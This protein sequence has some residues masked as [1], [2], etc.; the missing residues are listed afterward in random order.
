MSHHVRLS[1]LS[2]S[3]LTMSLGTFCSPALAAKPTD[4][5]AVA[6]SVD[7]ILKENLAEEGVAPADLTADEDFLRR[8]SI[9][10]TGR[11]PTPAEMTRFG[12]DPDPRKREKKIEELL[13]S[14][15]FAHNWSAYWRDVIFM[16]ATEQRAQPLQGVFQ[17]WIRE[18]FENNAPWDEIVTEMLTATG[19]VRENGATGLLLAHTGDAT[20]LASETSRLFLGIQIQCANCHDHPT[21]TWTRQQFH[22]LAAYFPRVRVQQ[23]P[24]AMPP[25]FEVSSFD[26]NRS[27]GREILNNPE[28]L[29]RGLDL[30]R[31]G[32]LSEAEAERAQRFAAVFQRLLGVGDTDKDRM[33]SL[34]EFKTLPTPPQGRRQTTEYFMPDLED[35]AAEGTR[36][37]PVFFVDGQASP[38]EMRDLERRAELARKVTDPNNEWFAKS[39]VNRI[40]TE[41]LGVGFYPLVD[42]MG[43]LRDVR[44]EEA[45]EALAAGFTA[46]GYDTRWVFRTILNSEAYQRTLDTPSGLQ[47]NDSC[48]LAC[49]TPVRLRAEQILSS[50]MMLSGQ[51]EPNR[52]I[53]VGRGPG[54]RRNSV[55]A[56]FVAL[57]GFDPSTPQDEVSGDIPQSL[58]MM[59]SPLISQLVSS[60][61]NGPLARL[62]RQYDSDEDAL[63]ELY[64]L[65]LS[66]E[67]S[68]YELNK[69]KEYI[70]DVQN[71]NEAFEDVMWCLVNSSEFITRR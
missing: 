61:G 63:R 39:Y 60:R 38:R 41:L 8:V 36:L 56:Q 20:E 26:V 54:S 5:L 50:L 58:F 34:E 28:R 35:P 11:I 68:E 59:N 46:S 24:Q 47:N 71:R 66:R 70:Y 69:C 48:E 45:L 52:D 25:T 33:L 21:D 19:D 64:V 37:D 16:R 65:V 29:F 1:L 4:P 10:L 7:R 49:A 13:D 43:P 15:D 14:P 32:K 53:V 23:R 22:E 18:K 51:T 67:P 62:L 2:L 27:G 9:D 57:F 42:D 17:M 3:L 55:Q 30:N 12:L 44:H 6:A 40:W 31:D